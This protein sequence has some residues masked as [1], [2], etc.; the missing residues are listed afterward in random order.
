MNKTHTIDKITVT[1]DAE[2]EFGD[3][4]V[5]KK[6]FG[7]SRAHCYRLSAEGKIRSASLRERG[8]TRGRRLWF[9]PSIRAF[10]IANMEG[11]AP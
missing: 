11:G 1:T 2:P 3:S 8:K 6:M 7:L 9:L 10:L 5:V 4:K